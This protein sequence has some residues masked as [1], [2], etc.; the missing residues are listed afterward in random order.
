MHYTSRN[1]EA[2]SAPM[3]STLRVKVPKD[4]DLSSVIRH[5]PLAPAKNARL[6]HHFYKAARETIE[7]VDVRAPVVRRVAA[8]VGQGGVVENDAILQRAIGGKA[9]VVVLIQSNGVAEVGVV[10]A[11]GHRH[12]DVGAR[13][14]ASGAR[15]IIGALK[16][17]GADHC[18]QR[19][20]HRAQHR[21]TICN[22]NTT[23]QFSS[24][25]RVIL[26]AFPLCSAPWTS[27]CVPQA[28]NTM[29]TMTSSLI[30]RTSRVRCRVRIFDEGAHGSAEPRELRNR[31]QGRESTC[32]MTPQSEASVSSSMTMW[33]WLI[34]TRRLS[35]S[36][37]LSLLVSL[38]YA[39]NNLLFMPCISRLF[40]QGKPEM[41]K[42][43]IPPHRMSP[44]K[45]RWPS[46]VSKD[47]HLSMRTRLPL[48]AHVRLPDPLCRRT[49]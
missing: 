39:F 49:G 48:T 11:R 46:C 12:A 5:E 36:S 27:R 13:G 9:L 25:S 35:R 6:I 28:T 17:R 23:A 19:D 14:V 37:L 10:V 42:V 33:T 16:D 24:R 45:V 22:Q 1:Y 40:Q 7:L 15:I 32:L 34:R 21:R 30:P 3:T 47:H 31:V 4:S 44:L 2:R 18:D 8:P 20:E 26:V 29:M 38:L 43:P 41:R